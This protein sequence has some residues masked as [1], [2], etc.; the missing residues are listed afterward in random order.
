[1][2]VGH[3]GRIRRQLAIST[4]SGGIAINPSA[5][6]QT[7]GHASPGWTLRVP[8]GQGPPLLRDAGLAGHPCRS[9]AFADQA[10]DLRCLQGA[11]FVHVLG[12]DGKARGQLA[13]S[14]VRAEPDFA[15]AVGI[16]AENADNDIEML[17]V[18][19]L[20]LLIRS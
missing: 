20:A 4:S 3:S 16:S 9:R 19:D 14:K 18:T 1:M 11:R 13:T 8:P 15:D 17:E 2:R 5:I 10:L 12:A 7:T 6:C